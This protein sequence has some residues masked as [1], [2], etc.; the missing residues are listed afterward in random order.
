RVGALSGRS[1]GSQSAGTPFPGKAGEKWRETVPDTVS[2]AERD[3]SCYSKVILTRAITNKC[4]RF[5]RFL[6]PDLTGRG[7]S[8]PGEKTSG[9]KTKVS[10]NRDASKSLGST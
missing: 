4:S 9:Q 8:H 3:S 7:S 1:A 6:L 2:P 5:Q 10:R